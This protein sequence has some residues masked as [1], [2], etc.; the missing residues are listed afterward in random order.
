MESL[1]GFCGYLTELSEESVR[2]AVPWKGSFAPDGPGTYRLR[3][4]VLSEEELRFGV[5]VRIR[6]SRSWIRFC[7][8]C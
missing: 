3:I 4:Q 5:E 1:A 7:F 2:L 8:L 6:G